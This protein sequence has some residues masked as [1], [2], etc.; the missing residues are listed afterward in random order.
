MERA[1]PRIFNKGGFSFIEVLIALALFGFAV[2]YIVDAAFIVTDDFRE[3][4]NTRELEQDLVWA[5][6][7]ILS[8]A[9][10]EK[11]SEGGDLPAP[12]IGEITWEATSEPTEILDLY[13]VSLTL[14]YDGNDDLGIEEGE[15]IFEMYVLRQGWKNHSDLSQD[16]S[17][18]EEDVRDKIREIQDS[19]RQ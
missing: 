18:L 15:T 3:V 4:E 1:F 17:R 2:V 11:F 10:Y 8:I 6:G 19:R 16:R 13:K 5:R 12:S 9:D 7:K 14:T